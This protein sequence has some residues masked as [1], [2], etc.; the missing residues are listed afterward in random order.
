MKAAR[1]TLNAPGYVPMKLTGT[2]ATVCSLFHRFLDLVKVR[3]YD[4]ALEKQ[5][6]K[7]E[8]K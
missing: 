3:H 6:A 5:N 1:Q 8:T 7:L 4:T 2:Q